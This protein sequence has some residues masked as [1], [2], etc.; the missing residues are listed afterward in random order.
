[1]AEANSYAEEAISAN[2]V[3]KWFTAEDIEIERYA[4]AVNRSYQVARRRAKLQAIFSPSVTFVAFGTLAVVMWVGGRQVLD[5]VLSAGSLVTFLLYTVTVAGA[6]GSVTGLYAQLQQTLG[7]TQRIFQLLDETKRR[8]G[9]RESRPTIRGGRPPVLR[10]RLLCLLGSRCRRAQR[11]HLKVEPG[12][13]LAIVGPSGA[14]KSTMVQ[15]IP[16]FFDP[17][18]GRILL[19]DVDLR[20]LATIE[21]RK[22]MAAVPRKPSCSLAPSP[23]TCEW[24][25]LMPPT[26]SCTKQPWLPMPTTSS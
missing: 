7:A 25:N 23:R 4:G 2:R 5:G 18:E 11:D 26:P 14:G 21:A 1:M 13:R 17:T 19:D 22:H 20:D 12:E 6:I 15:L 24:R 3:V 8:G 16:R 10:E 9:A